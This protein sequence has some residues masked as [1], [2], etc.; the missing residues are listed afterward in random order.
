MSREYEGYS[1]MIEHIA[2]IQP[3]R[4]TLTVKEI[5]K[6]EGH[7]P[8]TIRKRYQFDENGDISVFAYVLEPGRNSHFGLS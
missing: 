2:Y 5:A 4:T 3:G 8:R 6:M 1:Q 7:D